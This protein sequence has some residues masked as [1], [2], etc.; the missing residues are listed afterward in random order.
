MKPPSAAQIELARRLLALEAVAAG[1]DGRGSPAASRVYEKLHAH[2]SPLVGVAGVD[3]LFARSAK[4]AQG[5]LTDLVVGAP[6]EAPTKLRA[7]LQA[8]EPALAPDSATML[9]GT[10][11]TLLTTFIGERLTLQILRRVWPTLDETPLEEK[12]K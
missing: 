3:M 2:L 5:E 7:R 10:F 6:S 11:F 4:L 9:F 1:E 12:T 8:P